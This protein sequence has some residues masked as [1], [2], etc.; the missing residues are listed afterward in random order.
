VADHEGLR[1]TEPAV[2]RWDEAG[3]LVQNQTFDNEAL[4]IQDCENASVDEIGAGFHKWLM[5]N[6]VQ[7]LLSYPLEIEERCVAALMVMSREKY[8]ATPDVAD[9]FQNVAWL[10]S[11]L[12]AA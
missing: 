8:A 1:E 10:L 11:A 5:D 6:R 12:A 4:L 2:I 3:P 9:A 7:S